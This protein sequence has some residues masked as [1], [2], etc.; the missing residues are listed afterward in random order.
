[1]VEIYDLAKERKEERYRIRKRQSKHKSLNREG[2]TEE[3]HR[4]K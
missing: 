2:T 4:R 1:M 3:I